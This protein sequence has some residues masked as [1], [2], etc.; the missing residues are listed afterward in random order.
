MVSILIVDDSAIDR[1]LMDGLLSKEPDFD[2]WTAESASQALEQ[3]QQG[4]IDIVVTDLQM[5]DGDGLSLVRSI[6]ET[7]AETPSILVT[8]HGSEEIASQALEEG[9]AGYVNKTEISK[10]LVETIRNVWVLMQSERSYEKLAQH[11][12]KTEFKFEL[13]NDASLIPALVDLTQ[14]TMKGIADCESVERLRIAVCLEQALLNALYHGNLEVGHSYPI[15]AG[16]ELP[17]DGLQQIIQERMNDPLYNNRKI[18]VLVQIKRQRVSFIVRDDGKG[19]DHKHQVENITEG[20]RGLVL[21]RHFMDEV[22][23]NDSGNEITMTRFL[24]VRGN[25]GDSQIPVMKEE[26]RKS[27][28][29]VLVS[30]QSGREE[31]LT[32]RR[33][34]VGRRKSCHVVIPHSDVSSHHCQLFIEEGWW[35]VKDLDSSNGIKINGH[36]VDKGVLSPNDV[37][38]IGRHDYRIQYSPAEL[39]AVGPNRPTLR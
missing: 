22:S 19:F 8:A 4:M 10:R 27:H 15:P 17:E 2:V 38:S 26:S 12:L 36:K 39:G 37:L 35:C 20:G 34:L 24:G 5:P 16:D 33:V 31:Q 3:M 11:T 14:Q 29:G 7:Y 28:Y 21:I 6:N 18:K 25:D 1:Q 23:F 30:E 32:A 9:A 13:D